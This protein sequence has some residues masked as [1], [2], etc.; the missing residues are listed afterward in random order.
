MKQP[1]RN[2]KL[3]ILMMAILLLTMSTSGCG[4][5]QDTTPE[6]DAAFIANPDRSLFYGETLTIA[7]T[8]G[9]FDGALSPFQYLTRMYMDTNPG[10]TIEVINLWSYTQ[11]VD[12]FANKRDELGVQL[13][14]GSAPVLIC[15]MF[16]DYRD[17]RLAHFFAD[18]FPIMDADPNFNEDDWFMNVFHA[19]AIHDRLLAFPMRFD[20]EMVVANST[21]PGL[22]ETLA[23]QD[24]ITLSE[25]MKLHRE[26]STDSSFFLEPFFSVDQVVQFYLDSFLDFDT[27]LVDFDNEQFI[28]MITYAGEITS[29]NFE[30][31]ARGTHA[32]WWIDPEIEA[33]RSENYFFSFADMYQ[34]LPHL[35]SGPLFTE[36]TPLVNE[37]GEL[38]VDISGSTYVLNAN[39]SPIEQA[40]AWDFIQF[41][42][43]PDILGAAARSLHPFHMYPVNR[44]L[45]H[46]GASSAITI[47]I[48]TVREEFGWPLPGT[49]DES[50]EYVRAR[51]DTLGDMPMA[52]TRTLPFAVE[53]IIDEALEL[54][55]N[56]LVSAE[57]TAADL[58]NRVT[59]VLMEMGIN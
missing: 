49:I 14:A 55:Q 40:L 58:Q 18:W 28:D 11:D 51:T 45:F 24:S 21:I 44:H 6:I 29:P 26:M 31:S 50:V 52:S 12:R 33:Y 5:S 32:A 34:Y 4:S 1:T 13:M 20:Y 17:L 54:F 57:Q 3:A 15:G 25:L 23:A 38:L 35:E 16:V 2:K 59:L 7:T 22:S 53:N 10:V 43:N 9:G 8:F 41:S 37:R 39:A 47:W 27:G 42:M 48:A 36:Q 19:S 30:M 56:G 46:Q